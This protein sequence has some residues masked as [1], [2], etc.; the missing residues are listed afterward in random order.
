M[1][2]LLD[3]KMEQ[4]LTTHLDCV[5]NSKELEFLVQL[6]VFDTFAQNKIKNMLPFC[7]VSSELF[8]KV[9]DLG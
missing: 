5:E 3:H 4:S 6:L 8:I 2:P 9:R 1:T 7:L